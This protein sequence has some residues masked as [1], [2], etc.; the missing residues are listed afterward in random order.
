MI[1]FAFLMSHCGEIL[2]EACY[3]VWPDEQLVVE[4]DGNGGATLMI[5]E[6]NYPLDY[7]IKRQQ[8]FASEDAACDAADVMIDATYR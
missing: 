6:G 4:A 1:S 3:S 2:F 5:L 8:R 7:F